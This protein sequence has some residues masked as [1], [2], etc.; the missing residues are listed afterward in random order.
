MSRDARTR[1][2]V[3]LAAAPRAAEL[4]AW[5]T[6][7]DV[8]AVRAA[9]DQL[10]GDEPVAGW[11]V[12]VK[13]NIDVG[14]LPTTAGHPAF[15]RV[16]ASTAPAVAA[17][18]DAGAIVVGKTNL[19][20]FATGL[21]GTRTPFG[22]GRNPHSP[23]H[24]AG[25]SSSGSA[26][27]VAVGAAD[28]GIGTDTAGSGRV[29]AALCGIVGCKPTRGL[30]ST[31]GVVPAIAGLDCVSVFARSV[32]EAT[33]A[34]DLMSGFDAADPW[35]REAPVGTPAIGA[36]PLRVGVPR[37][38]DLD[39]LDPDAARAWRA[40]VE[41]LTAIGRVAEVDLS[42]YLAAGELLYGG[43]FVAARWHAF[44]EF[45]TSHPDGADPTVTAIVRAARDLDASALAAD[46]DHLQQLRRAVAGTMDGVDVL[47]VPTVG[48]APTLAAVRADP[49]EVNAGLGRYTN[50][51][52]LLDLCAVAVP[53]GARAD[54]LPFGITFL[55][56]AFADVLVATAAA[57][58][59]GEPDPAPPRWARWATVVVIGAHLTGQPLNHQLT[60]RGGRLLRSTST[61][62]V[63]R[64]HALA[65][66]P[67]KPGLVRVDAGGA[68]IAAELWQ[69]PLDRF[70]EFV[71]DVAAPLTIGTVELLDGSQHPGFLCEGVAAASA[72]DISHFG[73][74]LAYR[75]AQ[76]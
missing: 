73:G 68:P 62:P 18:I 20:Q 22:A 43:A 35:S 47:A 75:E 31:R 48:A 2:D 7:A 5:I 19:D 15:S 23:D 51:T 8:A 17:L 16:P 37:P 63:Y 71:L 60:A 40:A 39:R 30:V 44:G 27:A 42:P 72:P 55:G 50:A 74:W 6:R 53:A 38:V 61:A 76:R 56:R 12:A 45:L 70:G 59:A 41:S 29:P 54:G 64:L 21:V 36:G 58:F 4:G 34:L 11:T 69:V 3:A 25:G 14:G 49:I 32:G 33:T 9:A 67:P 1:A 66:D 52:N 46:I 26:I 24:I 13:D 10:A 57:R 28:I 65:T